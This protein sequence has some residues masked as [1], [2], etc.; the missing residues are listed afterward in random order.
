MLTINNLS[1]RFGGVTAVDGFNLKVSKGEIIALLGPNGSGKTTVVKMIAGLLHPNNGSIEISGHDL[2]KMPLQAKQQ[3]GYVPDDPF[4]WSGMT[5]AEFLGFTGALYGMD[6]QAR[7]ERI[8]ALLERFDIAGIADRAFE[9]YSRGN[10]QKFSILAGLLHR[11]E[12]LLV[13][14]PIVG[15]DPSSAEVAETL[16]KEFR[17]SGGS[18]LLVTHTLPVAERVADRIGILV[19]SK[20]RAFGTLSELRKQAKL[21]ADA[22][23]SRIYSAL[24]A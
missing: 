12:V 20:L 23:L 3:L 11:P 5:G 1:K 7:G 13:D 14:E 22:D 15:L 8:P 18:L 4:V 6:K 2:S 16:F 21:P 17:A 24:T 19:Y 9:D 10:K